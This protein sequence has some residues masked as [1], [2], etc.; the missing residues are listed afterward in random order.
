MKKLVKKLAG[1]LGYFATATP[2]GVYI[3]N[4]ELQPSEFAWLGDLNIQT[5][6]DV[7]AH[8]GQFSLLARR[9]FPAAKIIAFEPLKDGFDSLNEN[10]AGTT[11]FQS[12][13][14][15]LGDT[16]G[17]QTMHRSEFAPSSSLRKMG[18]LHK[19]A[20][21]HTAGGSEET[22]AVKTL[23]SAL[24]ELDV[25]GP[26]FLKIDVQGYEDAV[27][28]G[29]SKSLEKVDLLLIETSFFPLYE[30]QLLFDDIYKALINQ[31][32]HY[33]G[34]WG[35]WKKPTNGTILQQD[36]LFIRTE[37]TAEKKK[38]LIVFPDEWINYSPTV[39]NLNT[40]LQSHYNTEII[41][42]HLEQFGQPSKLP[43][44]K[45]ISISN[46]RYTL[47]R[48]LDK[49]KQYKQRL[50][51]KELKKK[52]S[53]SFDLVIAIDST[54]YTATRQYF[55]NVV[56][57]SLE[58][59]QDEAMQQA[60]QLGISD[61]I[62]QS[63]ERKEFLLGKSSDTRVH[64]I[65]NA[66]ILAKDPAPRSST[67]NRLVYFGN[68]RSYYGIEF[69]IDALT[70]LDN[71]YTLTLKG[72][73]EERFYQHLQSKYSD[74]ISSNRLRFEFDYTEQE[75]VADYLQDYDIGLSLFD[76]SKGMGDD[77]NYV[78]SPSGKIFNYFAAGIP[79]IGN[80]IVGFRPVKDKNAGILVE[81][82]SPKSIAQAVEAIS[83]N[84]VEYSQN[85]ALAARDFDFKAA[86]DIFL[87]SIQSTHA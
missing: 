56:F 18:Q 12:F 51:R 15:A 7:G 63:V 79:V 59:A 73:K 26:I 4:K 77:F 64:Y 30:G 74:L 57:L 70:H 61:L 1:L 3:Q 33:A 20:Y 46:F 48:R 86:Y 83:G 82:I 29:A 54:A 58:I 21:P 8:V 41:C 37:R 67:K 24:D 60:L 19:E 53:A 68:I 13:N 9:L 72:I 38:A 28:K 80:D 5:V 40:C 10:L 14:V 36:A 43:N 85:S 42:F 25:D 45:Q 23:D 6:I 17:A 62:I 75:K 66:P 22:I 87:A 47:L 78:S 44:L 31:G 69:C 35:Q 32:F 81:T 34:S 16:N 52:R 2:H 27:L 39:L 11:N 65:Q 55:D 84:Y 71:S 76:F 49:Y 50:L